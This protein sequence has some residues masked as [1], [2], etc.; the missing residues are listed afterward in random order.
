MR[1]MVALLAALTLT[2]TGCGGGG[3]KPAAKQTLQGS[4]L[5]V[6][7]ITGRL[8]AVGGPAGAS[9]TPLKGTVTLAGAN[10]STVRAEVGNDGGFEVQTS[11][12]RYRISGHSPSFDGGNGVCAAAKPEVTLVLGQTVTADVL[13]QRR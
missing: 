8:L 9:P 3:D 2:L 13:C 7:T 1:W 11:P 10:G 5:P 4:G 12:G 6:A